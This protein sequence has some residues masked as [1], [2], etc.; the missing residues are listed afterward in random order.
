MKFHVFYLVF[1][2]F[3]LFHVAFTNTFLEVCSIRRLLL[4]L[5]ECIVMYSVFQ[6]S[7]CQDNDILLILFHVAFTHT[8]LEVCSIRRLLLELNE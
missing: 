1:Y 5:N 2:Y 8:F 4:Q 3:I 6:H 7:L